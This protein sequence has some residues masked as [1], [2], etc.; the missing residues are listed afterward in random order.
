MTD[1]IATVNRQLRSL[2][3]TQVDSMLNIP[4]DRNGIDHRDFKTREEYNFTLGNTT[5]ILAPDDTLIAYFKKN[6]ALFNTIKDE[7]VA[8]GIM[9][10]TDGTISMKDIDNIRA[11]MRSV[12]IDE[13]MPDSE[14]SPNNLKFTI[15]GVLD[16]SVGYMYVKDKNDVPEMSPGL[17]IMIREIG[18]GWYLFKT[19]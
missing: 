14:S 16:N 1:I 15:G 8:K 4:P 13:A 5:L 6:K 3:K 12:F 10:T 11:Q 9:K 2:S 18:D 19:T 7:L 17:F